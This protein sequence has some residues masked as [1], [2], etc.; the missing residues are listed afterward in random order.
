MQ[1]V[2]KDIMNYV[3][4]VRDRMNDLR[5]FRNNSQNELD[6]EISPYLFYMDSD[7]EETTILVSDVDA[8]SQHRESILIKFTFQ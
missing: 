2:F 8:E 3:D 7:S 6:S 4:N 1:I 5:D